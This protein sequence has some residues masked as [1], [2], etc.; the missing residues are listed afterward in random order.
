MMTI[1]HLLLLA[2]LQSPTDMSSDAV[3]AHDAELPGV[4]VEHVSL[5]ELRRQVTSQD[6]TPVPRSQLKD[7]LRNDRSAAPVTAALPRIREAHYAARL[8]GNAWIRVSW[9]WK[10]IPNHGHPILVHC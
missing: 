9:I 1:W 6:Y 2:V 3:G 5:D 10:S 8:N 7:L 4:L